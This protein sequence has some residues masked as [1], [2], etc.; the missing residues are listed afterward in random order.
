MS[1][2]RHNVSY[3]ADRAEKATGFLTKTDRQIAELKVKYERDKRKAKKVWSATF[4]R[5]DGKNA[6]ERKC[7][8]EIHED[9]QLAQEA[10]M[11]SLLEYEFLSNERES[12]DRVIRFWQ[13]WQKAYGQGTVL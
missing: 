6:E 11:T 1:K 5:V 7:K 13:S 4:L 2:E 8:A 10:E 12:A 9:F 3:W